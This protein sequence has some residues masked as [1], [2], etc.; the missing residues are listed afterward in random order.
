MKRFFSDPR[1]LAL[2]AFFSIFLAGT[3]HA[4]TLNNDAAEPPELTE[5]PA[6]TRPV[7]SIADDNDYFGGWSDKYYTNHTRLSLTLGSTY[8][9]N[10]Q[11]ALFFSL[12][13]EIYSPK[14]REKYDPEMTDHPYAGYLYASV[15]DVKFDDDF[16]LAREVQIGATG[17][18][19]LA[20]EVQQAYHRLIGSVRPN[21]WETQIHSRF[22]AQFMGDIRKRFTLAGTL[23][24]GNGADV[25]VRGFCGIGNLRGEASI[26][27]EWRFGMNLPKDFGSPN[28]RQ[29]TSV[30][31]DPQVDFSVYGFLDLQGDAIFWDETLT[32]NN[33]N[34]TAD[35]YA[36]PVAAQA[37]IGI[38]A[39]YK[40][41]ALTFFQSFRTKDFSTQDKDFFAYGGF[42]L[43]VI[44]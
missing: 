20:K 8:E 22:V 23:G 9:D 2:A 31:F 39:I 26:G 27:S 41:Y 40:N 1:E 21:G 12:G 30:T 6:G 36:Y 4:E 10:A 11:R 3:V 29:S 14:E 42:K 33:D 43:S 37:T 18:Y 5:K 44:F 28:M 38:R 35:I 25:I 19:S 17:E 16:A 34:G 15:G 13:Q 24:N 7:F 32:G